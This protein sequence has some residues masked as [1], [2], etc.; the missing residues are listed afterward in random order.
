MW[1]VRSDSN[2]LF[3]LFNVQLASV[4]DLQVAD[5]AHR[6]ASGMRS[7]KVSGL[8]FVLER[9]PHADLSDAERE[10]VVRCKAVAIALFA[11]EHGGT[12]AVWKERPLRPELLE[13]CTDAQY[14]FALR[15]SYARGGGAGGGG[16]GGGGG[17]R[18][19]RPDN[20][21]ERLVGDSVERATA[22]RLARSATRDFKKGDAAVMVAVDPVLV[23]DVRRVRGGGGG[24][25]GGKGG[26]VAAAAAAAA[27]APRLNWWG[28]VE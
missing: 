13:Y 20:S 28:E 22:R 23:E 21:F 10:R 12:Y 25:G 6:I 8:G 11:P 9:T 26:G 19:S 16:W 4:L 27:A 3:F 18:G 15:D 2:A 7:D 14:F 1:D 24:G 17:G 5:C